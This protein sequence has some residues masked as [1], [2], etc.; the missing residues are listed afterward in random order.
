MTKLFL[1][2]GETFNGDGTSPDAAT[3]NGG[4]GAFNDLS[5]VWL[6]IQ[7]GLTSNDDVY[8]YTGGNPEMAYGGA[9]NHTCRMIAFD[10]GTEFGDSGE[11]KITHNGN[12]FFPDSWIVGNRVLRVEQHS[13][14][15]AA[16]GF[17]D[18]MISGTHFVDMHPTQNHTYQR[19]SDIARCVLTD[20][21]FT[22]KGYYGL[23]SSHPLFSN[24]STNSYC[25][26]RGITVNWN[27]TRTCYFWRFASN[28]NF[29]S[30]FRVNGDVVGM[31]ALYCSSRA[32][33]VI[34]GVHLENGVVDFEVDGGTGY[35][36]HI[37]ISNITVGGIG[38]YDSY[39][40]GD[41]FESDTRIALNYPSLSAYSLDDDNSQFS[42]KVR[43]FD[44]TKYAELVEISKYDTDGGNRNLAMSFLLPDNYTDV[45]G[46]DYFMIVEYTDNSNIS[47]TATSNVNSDPVKS[48]VLDN[49][50]ATVY[51]AITFNPYRVE[52]DGLDIRPKS[53]I[54]VKFVTTRAPNN[55]T[56]FFFVDPEVQIS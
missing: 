27:T 25:Y 19:R 31:V 33:A 50:S 10:D 4:V 51:G 36:G 9:T 45:I 43:P 15:H 2:H 21:E 24:T 34:D 3:S 53:V 29:I 28:E 12:F 30:N 47:R 40:L 38:I 48:G 14:S 54:N 23:N 42:L 56:E 8:V 37:S 39:Y 1:R 6:G 41:F 17:A 16:Y 13:T 46:T 55:S 32:N 5:T 35:G 7:A 18:A 22:Y 11:F 44:V 52:V 49:W 26:L 20:C